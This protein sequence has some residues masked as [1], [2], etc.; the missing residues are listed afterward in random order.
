MRPDLEVTTFERSDVM[1]P[2]RTVPRGGIVRPLP[3]AAAPL[4][5]VHFEVAG[6]QYD[7]FDYLALNRVAGLLVLKN[8]KVVLEDMNWVLAPRRTGHLFQW[9]SRSLLR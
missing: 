3:I 9:Q 6:K 4:K 2:V 7:L 1:F 5:N 8:G